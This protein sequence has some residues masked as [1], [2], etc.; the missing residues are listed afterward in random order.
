MVRIHGGASSVYLDGGAK[1]ENNLPTENIGG[2]GNNG[3]I[4]IEALRRTY[5]GVKWV[6]KNKKYK[7]GGGAIK[8]RNIFGYWPPDALYAHLDRTLAE[9]PRPCN[10]IN[11][12]FLLRD[13][14]E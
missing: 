8:F 1:I 3:K 6:V 10:E 7:V 2:T 11:Y 4:K 12:P 14:D 5:A 9:M 13:D